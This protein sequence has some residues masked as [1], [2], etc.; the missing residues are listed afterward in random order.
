MVLQTFGTMIENTD[1]VLNAW[2]EK[3]MS[4]FK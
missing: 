2:T 3:V 1:D 4:F